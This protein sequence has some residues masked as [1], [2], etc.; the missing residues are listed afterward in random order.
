MNAKSALYFVN[1]LI[2]LLTPQSYAESFPNGA[3]SAYL[4]GDYQ[5]AHKLWLHAAR[6]GNTSAQMSLG[7]LYERGIGVRRDDAQAMAWYLKAAEAGLAEAQYRLGL[8]YE[9]GKG[10]GIDL[11]EAEAWYHRATDQGLCPGEIGDPEDFLYR[12]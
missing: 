4:K 10:A 11:W 3:Y 2:S 8:M 1:I 5:A 7:Y 6:S 12:N 9:L